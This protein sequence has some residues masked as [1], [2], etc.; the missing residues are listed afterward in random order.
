MTVSDGTWTV[1]FWLDPACPLTRHTARW[2][3][4]VASEVPID[5]RWR[6]MSLSVLNEHRA[7]DPEGDPNGFLWVPARVATA[8]R[9]GHGHA[10]LGGFY[11]ALWISPDGAEREWIGDIPEALRR[12]G[13]PADLADAGSS[14]EYDDALR[15]SHHDAV[16]RIESETGTPVLTVTTPAGEQRSFFGP[17]LRSTPED[18]DALRLW[19]AVHLLTDAPAF[20]ELKT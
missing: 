2:L 14:T 1:D 6:V 12:S 10:A 9:T 13:L 16:A 3:S 17:V 15:A 19:N 8:V 18:A 7:D 5:V 11:D 4:S 20:R